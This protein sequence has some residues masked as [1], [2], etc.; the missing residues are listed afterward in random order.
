[1]GR[2]REHVDRLHAAQRISGLDY[3]RCVG[4]K[5]RGVARDVDD[6]RRAGLEQAADD[7][8]RQAGARR[9]DDDRVR[10]SRALD[11]RRDPEPGVGAN[12]L[13]V[14]DPVG[15][16]VHLGVANRLGHAL[17]APDLARARGEREP[18]RADAAEEVEQA[19]AA[20]EVGEVAGDRVEA[21]GHLGVGLHEGRVRD[22]KAQAAELLHQVLF[23]EDAGRS[24]GAAGEALDH[25]VQIDGWP[26]DLVGRGDETGLDLPGPSALADDEIAQRCRSLPR[27]S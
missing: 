22:A 4:R 1:M 23:A 9:V 5:R 26:R 15:G 6:P 18:D 20:V 27:L 3:L 25:R 19:L 13:G 24:V 7:L 16:G 14:L 17:E 10:P 2:L 21:L 8:L 11:Q 12:E